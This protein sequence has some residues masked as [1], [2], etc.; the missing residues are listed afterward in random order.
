MKFHILEVRNRHFRK[1]KLIVFTYSTKAVA[2]E[3][4]EKDLR[5]E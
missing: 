4:P 5:L 2:E 3:K 1:C